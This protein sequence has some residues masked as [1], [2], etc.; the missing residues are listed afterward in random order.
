MYFWALV[1]VI[2]VIVLVIL[3]ERSTRRQ[4]GSMLRRSGEEARSA[5]RAGDFSRWRGGGGF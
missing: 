3:A 2:G 1:L 5:R 4:H